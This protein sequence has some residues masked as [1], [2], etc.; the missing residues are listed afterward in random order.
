M[1]VSTYFEETFPLAVFLETAY[2]L[3]PRNGFPA[4]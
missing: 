3:Y 1:V 4:Q 2:R